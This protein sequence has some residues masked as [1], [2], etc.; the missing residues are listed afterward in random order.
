[1][2]ISTL[3]L[4][5]AC[6]FLVGCGDSADASMQKAMN[7][8]MGEVQRGMQQA[9]QQMAA[10]MPML[11]QAWSDIGKSLNGIA[12]G[13]TAQQAKAA[14]TK[15]VADLQAQAQQLGGADKLA[16]SLGKDAVKALQAQVSALSNNADVQ[17]AVGPVLEQL[18]ALLPR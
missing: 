3:V 1:M 10:A 15:L 4:V 16:A 17:K 8:A 18:R 2:K 14:L 9:Q 6:A 11:Q 13:A 7:Q 12:D 5:S